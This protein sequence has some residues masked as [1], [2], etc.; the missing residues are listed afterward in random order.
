MYLTTHKFLFNSK[1]FY[2]AYDKVPKFN[3]TNTRFSK[4]VSMIVDLTEFQ[5][6]ELANN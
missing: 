1:I 4:T 5:N 6:S 2:L 3:N